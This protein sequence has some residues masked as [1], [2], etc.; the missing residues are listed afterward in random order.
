MLL[1]THDTG[2]C[3]L[4]GAEVPSRR[5]GLR[6]LPAGNPQQP[7]SPPLRAFLIGTANL[8]EIDLTRSQQTRKHFLI[9]TNLPFVAQ[10]IL[11]VLFGS[12]WRQR[13]RTAP[14]RITPRRR[15]GLS[16]GARLPPCLPGW[17]C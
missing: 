12:R 2:A 17:W 8:L 6:S 16:A 5:V 15:L 13:L 9:G 10:A 11:P 4:P 3:P 1:L 7:A 14:P